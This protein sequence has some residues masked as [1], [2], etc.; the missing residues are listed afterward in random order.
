[1]P[2]MTKV[3]TDADITLPGD[4]YIICED[5]T[6]LTKDEWL[7]KRKTS[8]VMKIKDKGIYLPVC[9]GG[10]DLAAIL[11]ISPW[12]TALEKWKLLRGESLAS[13]RA[14][15]EKS[16]ALGHKFEDEIAQKVAKK[17]G[18]R[19][20][21]TKRMYQSRDYPWMIADFDYLAV[22]PDGTL[23]GLEIKYTDSFNF[24]FKR[25]VRN[26]GVPIYYETQIRHYMAVS[27]L[28]KWY[29]G[30]GSTEGNLNNCEE[31]NNVEYTFLERDQDMEDEFVEASREF[32][33][34]VVEGEEP[35]IS[36]VEN[37]TMGMESLFR[38]YG[39]PDASKTVEF[40]G[41]ASKQLEKV[42]EQQKR[43]IEAQEAVKLEEKRLETLML[44][45]AQAM[46]DASA[47]VMEMPDGSKI[48]AV[49]KTKETNSFSAKK[50]KVVNPAIFEKYM[51]AGGPL[52]KKEM[53]DLYKECTE[54]TVSR[55]LEI[56][57]EDKK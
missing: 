41:S 14:M 19:L 9:W 23:V 44:P 11:N 57:K 4:P 13:E 49:Y 2:T 38:V 45:I 15:P 7:M 30:V 29:I 25:L 3:I 35:D 26:G 22:E 47:G 20:I 32:I 10:S 24:D 31:I 36:S 12:G 27:G 8:N 16:L 55:T 56:K 46:G 34:C 39:K 21:E 51:S 17:A 37:A 42:L 43:I 52:L 6:T 28:A 33:R 48:F 40:S 1:M 18:L 53:P 5:I 54:T 50:L